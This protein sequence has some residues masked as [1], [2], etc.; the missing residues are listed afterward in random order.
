MPIPRLACGTLTEK[1]CNTSVTARAHINYNKPQAI[2]SDRC[3]VTNQVHCPA[4]DIKCCVFDWVVVT[5]IGSHFRPATDMVVYRTICC[6]PV[7]TRVTGS[8]LNLSWHE[9]RT[10]L[11]ADWLALSDNRYGT[12]WFNIYFGH[13]S[14]TYCSR[15]AAVINFIVV[16]IIEFVST[17]PQSAGGRSGIKNNNKFATCK[18]IN[19]KCE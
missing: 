4:G 15:G 7:L 2:V 11:I 12:S 17:I 13:Y 18:R 16:I 14:G 19:C 1:I 9:H 6:W 3:T 8:Y 10:L 5:W